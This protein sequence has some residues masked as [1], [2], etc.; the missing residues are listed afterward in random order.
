MPGGDPA[1]SRSR[2]SRPGQGWPGG[3]RA[4]RSSCRCVDWLSDPSASLLDGFL[5]A[6][7]PQP[8]SPPTDTAHPRTRAH[9]Q[10]SLL[11]H[12]R[13]LHQHQALH[14][15]QPAAASV[16]LVSTAGPAPLCVHRGAGGSERAVTRAGRRTRNTVSRDQHRSGAAARCS[17]ACVPPEFLRR[18]QATP[19]QE[20]TCPLRP[21]SISL[22]RR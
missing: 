22:R 13:E 5:A 1:A 3:S 14:A 10:A 12:L 7:D 2:A 16:Q 11:A 6:A 17:S 9:A 15:S 21:S 18:E 8:A 20:A 19:P 4:P